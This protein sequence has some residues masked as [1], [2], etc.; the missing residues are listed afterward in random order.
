MARTQ[1]TPSLVP[2]KAPDFIAWHVQ[3]KGEKSYWN[4]VGASWKHKDGKGMTLQLET[5]PINGRIV[6]R[7]PQDESQQ[8]E[9]ARQ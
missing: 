3:Q 5:L 6:L 7:Q 9:G 8:V 1:N 2:P 4:K